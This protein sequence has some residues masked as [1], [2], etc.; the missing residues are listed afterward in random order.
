LTGL[1]GVAAYSVLLAH[2]LNF[3]GI[4]S[5][6]LTALAYFGMSLF[7][8]L[9]GF[10]IQYN[11]GQSF[12]TGPTTKAARRF[13]LARFA[14][15]Y[16][17]YLLGLILSVSFPGMGFFKNIWTALS[18]ITLTQTWFN[19]HGATGDIIGGS[20]SI[21]TEFFLY[22][23][24]IPAAAALYA[25]SKPLPWL[26]GLCC[27]AVI[28]V[29]TLGYFEPQISKFLAP[30]QFSNPRIS[31]PPFYWLIYFSPLV[32]GFEF[33]GG[34]LAAQAYLNGLGAKR[35]GSAV[36]VVISL[37]LAWC[38]FVILVLCRTENAIVK[39][40]LPNF[41]FAPAI[42][43]MLIFVCQF[44]SYLSRLLSSKTLLTAGDISYSVY[45]L[46]ALVFVAVA[47]GFAGSTVS[48]AIARCIYALL[49]TTALGYGVYHL[50]EAP[51]RAW[52][53]SWGRP[54]DGRVPQLSPQQKL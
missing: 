27:T 48:S 51:A 41:I 7:F 18:C 14:R 53:R 49:I 2:A 54:R 10:V 32:R 24:F 26:I 4:N 17:L 22:L 43:T 46:Q 5:P 33:F 30:L 52:I 37:C 50:F 44:D 38:I 15:L 25:I 12:A 34:A 16:P 13:L 36:P 23:V 45:L 40:L 29:A 20:W 9:S 39:A 21:S 35:A 31:A 19:V 1:R 28:V 47:N 11:Y 3:S 42:L 6:S 8:T